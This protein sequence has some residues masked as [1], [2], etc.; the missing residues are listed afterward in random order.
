VSIGGIVVTSASKGGRSH[1]CYPSR[2]G[3]PFTAAEVCHSW[4]SW[5]DPL[6]EHG[7]RLERRLRNEFCTLELRIVGFPSEPRVGRAVT[8]C[9]VSSEDDGDW[10][11]RQV[12]RYF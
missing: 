10:L 3:T 1:F 12:R 9:T 11:A 5:H 6:R 8:I 7:G 2:R 4:W